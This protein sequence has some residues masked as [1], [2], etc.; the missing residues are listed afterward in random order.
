MTDT[1]LF[2]GVLTE[3]QF[4]SQV[5][6]YNESLNTLVTNSN[7]KINPYTRKELWELSEEEL[8]QLYGKRVTK[9][10]NGSGY[11]KLYAVD[12]EAYYGKSNPI[13]STT[14]TVNRGVISQPINT[15]KNPTTGKTVFSQVAKAGKNFKF[16]AGAAASAV[17]AA[18][19]GIWLGKTIDST[20]Y[21]ANP[22]FWDNIGLSSL[23]PQRWG[24]ITRG[25]DSLG[26]NLFNFIFGIDPN[27][28][29]TQAY[30]D[31]SAAAYMAMGLNRAG[32]FNSETTAS[33]PPEIKQQLDPNNL[34]DG[35]VYPSN[36]VTEIIS[37]DYRTIGSS[38]ADRNTGLFRVNNYTFSKPLKLFYKE[39]YYQSGSSWYK[40]TMAQI[41]CNEPFDYSM[42]QVYYNGDTRDYSGSVTTGY[43]FDNKTVYKGNIS[44]ENSAQTSQTVL[45]NQIPF[46]I[47]LPQTEYR[48]DLTNTN[49]GDAY[50]VA[51]WTAWYGDVETGVNVDGIGTQEQAVLPNF[52]GLETLDDY[53]NYLRSTYP[54]TYADS[55]PITYLDENGDEQTTEYI[56]VPFPNIS[57]YADTQPTSG[58]LTQ[59]SVQ[60]LIEQMTQLLQQYTT[61]TNTANPTSTGEGTTQIIVAPTGS[62]SNLWSIYHPTQAQVDSFGGWLWSPSFIDQIAKIFNNP[63]ESIIGLHKVYATPVDAGNTTIHVGY[64]DSNVPSAYITQQYIEVDCGTV[65]LYEQFGNVFDYSPFTDVQLY[66]PFIG[67]VPLSVDDVMRSTISITYGV[68]VITGACLAMVD[69]QRDMYGGVLY[70][71]SGNC[72]V[73][74]PISSGSYMGIVAGIASIAGGLA[75]T[76]ASGGAAAPAL[77][78]A[79]GGAMSMHTQVQHSGSFSGNAGAMGGKV[80]YLIVSRPITAMYGYEELIEG[81]PANSYV[82]VGECSGYVKARSVDLVGVSA[83]DSELSEIEAL[84]LEGVFV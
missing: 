73:Q 67:I 40:S 41:A 50:K 34:L 23:N 76:V 28:G 66:L 37:Y 16:F 5:N 58:E 53:D 33:I 62:A 77:L 57:N 78:G 29:E 10:N 80:P 4:L 35:N 8:S 46:N 43:T 71:Y 6:K 79:A 51:A 59:T 44:C 55:V 36:P 39:I 74:Y 47:I 61:P 69:V 32:I 49:F 19:V 45:E 31:S 20:L 1:T 2:T 14:K 25:D 75:A 56:P 84:L 11:T 38:Y 7:E 42:H 52:T 12:S 81:Y 60:Q 3:E 82:T 65:D 83:T 68:D 70:Q 26:S 72:A 64:L 22:D 63:M 54:Q 48:D 15:T 21:N 13:N 27:T 30:I 18:S 17:T 9:I 24:D